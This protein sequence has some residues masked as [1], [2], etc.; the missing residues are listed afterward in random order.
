MKPKKIGMMSIIFCCWACCGSGDFGMVNCCA[1]Q[2]ITMST[3]RTRM[4]Y[5][6]PRT[7]MVSGRERSVIHQMNPSWRMAIE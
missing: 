4:G 3:G 5:R 7:A 2:E 6:P 1:T